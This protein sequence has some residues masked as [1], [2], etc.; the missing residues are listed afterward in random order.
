[1]LIIGEKEKQDGLVTVRYLRQKKQQTMK[2]DDFL[3]LLVM[4]EA[5]GKAEVIF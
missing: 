2:L 5:K 4:E 1:M 3:Q